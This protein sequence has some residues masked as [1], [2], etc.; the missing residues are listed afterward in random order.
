[1][2][3]VACEEKKTDCTSCMTDRDYL[4]DVLAVEK[5]I[6]N[7]TSIAITE[8][9]NENLRNKLKKIYD[10]VEEDQK[11]TFELAWNKG[12][13]T[14]ESVEDQKIEETINNLKERYEELEDI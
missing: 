11:D 7:N 12:W 3:K 2:T 9:S 6:T 5:Q 14:L 4:N 1:M 13:Y 8:A 10:S